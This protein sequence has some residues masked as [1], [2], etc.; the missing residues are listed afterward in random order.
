MNIDLPEVKHFDDFY[1]WFNNYPIKIGKKKL[2][3]KSLNINM[4]NLLK[5]RFMIGLKKINS[6][7]RLT[8]YKNIC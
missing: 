3:K 8:Y 1:I 7:K 5:M 6:K 2:K 4:A